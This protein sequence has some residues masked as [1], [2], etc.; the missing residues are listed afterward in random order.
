MSRSIIL[1]VE[2]DAPAADIYRAVTTKQGLSSFWTPQVTGRPEV[3][4]EL[5]FGFS[6]APVDLR[7]TVAE[8]EENRLVR[9]ACNGPWP[10]WTGTEVTWTIVASDSGGNL[11][12]FEHS[13][14]DEAQPK[15]EF[16]AIAL[17]WARVLLALEEHVRTGA[18]VPAL[19]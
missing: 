12:V 6:E 14:W 15:A 5:G 1:A 3:G 7:M 18:A 4:A 9:W 8:L 10:Y 11:A 2:I 13:G 17:V 16:G 19:A